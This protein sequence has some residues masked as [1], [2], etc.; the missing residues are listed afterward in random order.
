MELINYYMYGVLA[1]LALAAFRKVDVD[2]RML[3]ILALLWPFSFAYMAATVSTWAIGWDMDLD[4]NRQGK[5]F[6]F[7]R[8]DDNWTGFAITVL[9]LEFMFWKKRA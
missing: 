3:F 2:I 5:W 9:K 1:L 6:G 7:R 8:P 4:S